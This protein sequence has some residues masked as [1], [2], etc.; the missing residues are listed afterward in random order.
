MERNERGLEEQ[1]G[2][3]EGHGHRDRRAAEAGQGR[4]GLGVGRRPGKPVDERQ[5]EEHDRRAQGAQEEVL[6]ARLRRPPVL[7]EDPGQ[8]VGRYGEQ[9]EG[10]IGRDDVRGRNGRHHA[11]HG[12]ESQGIDLAGLAALDVEETEGQD[13]GQPAGQEDRRL[14]VESEGVDGEVPAEENGGRGRRQGE[15]GAGRG[16]PGQGNVARGPAASLPTKRWT[17]RAA[18]AAAS[19]TISGARGPSAYPAGTV[20]AAPR[21]ARD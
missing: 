2:E 21:S 6:D 14:G 17:A 18:I 1:P 4:S 15:G 12:Q 9:L 16:D 13:E 19:S 3:D 5:A 7:L 8:N 11:D 10:D 20:I